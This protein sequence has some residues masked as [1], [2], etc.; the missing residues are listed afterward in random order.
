MSIA[1]TLVVSLVLVVHLKRTRKG[2]V[3]HVLCIRRVVFS[4]LAWFPRN[5]RGVR[6]VRGPQEPGPAPRR[7]AGGVGV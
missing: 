2:T 1:K 4:C 7:D 3:L 6:L 5:S